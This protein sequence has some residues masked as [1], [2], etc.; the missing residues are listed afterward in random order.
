MAHSASSYKLIIL[1]SSKTELEP[2]LIISFVF[3]NIAFHTE[4]DAARL[5]DNVRI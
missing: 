3:V 5:V 2:T 4:D 1:R